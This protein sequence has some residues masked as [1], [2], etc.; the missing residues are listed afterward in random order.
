MKAYTV[1]DINNVKKN[2]ILNRKICSSGKSNIIRCEL[3]DS[4]EYRNKIV[5][6]CPKNTKYFNSYNLQY[7]SYNLFKNIKSK[8]KNIIS[9]Q[10]I[11]Y[12][13]NSV[14]GECMI[15]SEIP[16]MIPI[17]IIINNDHTQADEIIRS[18]AKAISYMHELGVSGFDSEFYW[19][20]KQHKLI[21]LDIGPPY[22]FLSDV[23]ETI[24]KQFEAEK[25]NE[26]GFINLVSQIVPQEV[27]YRLKTKSLIHNIT[28]QEILKMDNLYSNKFHIKNVAKVHALDILGRLKP[29]IQKKLLTIFQNEYFSNL[30]K[31]TE[32]NMCYLNE[33]KN[34]IY[35]NESVASA[36]LFYPKKKS[37]GKSCSNVNVNYSGYI[38]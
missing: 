37:I 25:N 30:H 29:D 7:I 11:F 5:V 15:M 36:R 22:T 18:I 27:F 12:G 21:V 14:L 17:D 28:I 13:K 23:N 20:I 24:Y 19:D 2:I 26:V 33:F 8:Y 32:L 9:P 1:I 4:L 35:R 34:I 38:K 31:I 3:S 16:E 6:K 10:V